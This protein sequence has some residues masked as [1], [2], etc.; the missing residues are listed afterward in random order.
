MER[1][2]QVE[3]GGMALQFTL[4]FDSHD[5][6]GGGA[7]WGGGA[8][9]ICAPR[10]G[11]TCDCIT[12]LKRHDM[13]VVRL[14]RVAMVITGCLVDAVEERSRGEENTT[15]AVRVHTRPDPYH[16]N[17]YTGQRRSQRHNLEQ[18]WK[19]QPRQRLWDTPK[20]PSAAAQQSRL[21]VLEQKAQ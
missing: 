15:G 19:N 10:E 7:G 21:A 9:G 20:C 18:K 4:L 12:S 17:I 2:S 3:L 16:E 11:D 1:V 14:A 5:L 6:G 8:A 13:H